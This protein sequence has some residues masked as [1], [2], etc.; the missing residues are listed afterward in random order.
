M[1]LLLILILL[2]P[3]LASAGSAPGWRAGWGLTR[4]P[5]SPAPAAD[6]ADGAIARLRLEPAGNAW[7]ARV[8]NR[9]AGPVQIALRLPHAHAPMASG[10]P[11]L[12][13]AAGTTVFNGLPAPTGQT[14]LDLRLLAV[15]GDPAARTDD[16]TYALPFD[17]HRIRISQPPQGH[18]SHRDAENRDAVDFALPEGTPVLAARAGTVMQV[19]EGFHGNGQ[20]ILH[21][22]Q[23]ANFI[24][25]LHTD[26]SMAVY[27]HLQPGGVRV[28][29]GQHVETGQLIGLSGN[30]G[31]S[32]A[33]HLHFVVQVNRGMRL[34]SVPVRLLGPHGELRFA[35]PGPAR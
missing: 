15:P 4:A 21:D 2:L 23:R 32:T 22:G 19:Q 13:P 11:R 8:D 5:A 29:P 17:A 9:I 7:R 20:D 35:T 34:H 24:R 28:R 25:L 33:P 12:L 3:A 27:A 18:A 6:A 14:P 1:R 30:T 16:V 31:Y 26:G 10:P